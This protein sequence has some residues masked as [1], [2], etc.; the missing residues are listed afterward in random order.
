M[1]IRQIEFFLSAARL[2]GIQAAAKEHFVTQPAVS[3]QIRK[4]EEEIGE[5]LLFRRGRKITLTPA[6]CLFAE[7]AEEII[8]RLSRLENSIKELRGCRT[9]ILRIGAIDAAGVYVLPDVLT[10]FKKKFPGID[11]TISVSDSF[12]LIDEL[13]KDAVEMAIV[14]LP[15]ERSDLECFPVYRDKMILVCSPEHELS[16]VRRGALKA[17]AKTGLI[18]YPASSTTRKLIEGVFASAGLSLRTVME[19]SSPEAIKRLTETGLGASV[20]PL[21]VVADELKKGALKRISTG[22]VKFH[23]DLG[24]ALKKPEFLSPAA[25]EFLKF[26][27]KRRGPWN[28]FSGII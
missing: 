15:V 3:I 14:T 20:L 9:G 25:R 19:V 6:G 4:L 7:Q 28:K 11:I 5:R 21:P 2:G 23:R 16:G 17:V 1:E 13:V 26:L 27:R 8:A 12:H 24:V 22:K 10:G 18:T